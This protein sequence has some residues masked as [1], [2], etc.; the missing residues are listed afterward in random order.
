MVAFGEDDTAGCIPIQPVQGPDCQH[1]AAL[2][3]V[4]GQVIGQRAA[5]GP[6]GRVN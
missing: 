5:G 1:E 2:L 3:Q 4:P 6:T